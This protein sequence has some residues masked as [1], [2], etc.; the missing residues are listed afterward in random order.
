MTRWLCLGALCVSLALLGC[1]NNAQSDRQASAEPVE[2]FSI[3]ITSD[4]V[5]LPWRYASRHG[6]L[7]DLEQQHGI[8]LDMVEFANERRALQ[9][10]EN[11]DIDGITTS[12]N[13]IITSF[14]LNHHETHIPLI[15]GFSRGDYGIFSREAERLRDLRGETI[16]AP[17]GSSG[18]YFLFRLLELNQLTLED[19]ELVD[20]SEENIIEGLIDGE[21]ENL[22]ASGPTFVQLM[23]LDDVRLVADSRSLYGEVM[24]GVAINADT[25]QNHPTLGEIIVEAWFVITDHLFADGRN[26][27]V[28]STEAL[29][30]LS[31]LPAERLEQYLGPQNFLRSPEY[32]YRFMN[33]ENL[34]PALIGT[35]RFRKATNPNQCTESPEES[36]DI[37]RNGNL[38]SNREG[39]EILLDTRFV[40]NMIESD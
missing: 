32:V 17:L 34:Q 36:C 31:N 3:G 10:Y 40:Q 5:T 20:T 14:E 18:H 29:E 30:R 6:L 9:A 33:G 1:E 13:A 39:A 11:G 2:T 12:L 15:F 4:I 25:L 19:V 35:E 37:T 16:H 27:S 22:V 24:A 28:A 8:R 26:L 21:I 23:Q 38:I 7:S